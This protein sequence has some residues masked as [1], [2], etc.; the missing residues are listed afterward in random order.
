MPSGSLHAVLGDDDFLVRQRAREI[1]D[2]LTEKFPDDLSREIIDGRAD[3]VE[4]VE[5][6]LSEAKSACQTLSLFGG[7]KLVWINEA[8]FLNQSKTGAAQGS[9]DALDGCKPFL[10]KLGDSRL[11]IS[12]CPV[13]RN[14]QF[15]KWLQKNSKFEDVAKQEKEE[16]SF[17]RLVEET[18]QECNVTFASGAIEYLSG[19]IGGHSRLGVEETRKLASYVGQEGN[20]ITEELI[21][22][23]VPD[24]GEGDFF[25]AS[26]AFFSNDLKWALDAIERHFFHAKD[27]RPLLS[28]LQN[29]NRL[30]IQLRVLADGGELEPNQRLSKEKLE[31]IGRK[32]AHHFSDSGEK[33]SLN[34]FS[35]N[36]W[37]LGRLLPIVKK[38][39]TRKLIDLQS[40]LLEAFEQLLIQP[41]E[42]QVN[43]F[44]DLAIRTLSSK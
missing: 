27:A 10:E 26:E 11:I 6:I 22:E 42:R 4:D 5:S 21:T 8:N 32:H 16:V 20:P 2:D 39:N 41:R 24:F 17:R 12:A 37:F 1:F 18:A 33:S 43:I 14:H 3:R 9:K 29:R 25:E 40:A 23:L 13:H 28:T 15:I 38:F 7:G 30:L 19:K 35:Q 44:K 31:Q 36:P 34:L